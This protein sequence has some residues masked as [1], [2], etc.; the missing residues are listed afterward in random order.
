MA[1]IWLFI[2][3]YLHCI[4]CLL[5]DNNTNKPRIFYKQLTDYI[6]EAAWLP[7]EINVPDTI[8]AA[9]EGMNSMWSSFMKFVENN[10]GPTSGSTPRRK[11]NRRKMMW[12][13]NQFMKKILMSRY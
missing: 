1:F 3:A 9:I 12:Q 8:G 4:D 2:F 7:I 13:Q 11:K 6:E 5:C 10:I